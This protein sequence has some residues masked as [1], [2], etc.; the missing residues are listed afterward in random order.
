M[1]LGVSRPPA[2]LAFQ[3]RGYAS[4]A[5][6]VV[7]LQHHEM[8]HI[9]NVYDEDCAGKKHACIV[10]PSEDAQMFRSTDRH[11]IPCECI[12]ELYEL[13]WRWGHQNTNRPG[14]AQNFGFAIPDTIVVVK[15]RPYAWYFVSKKDG[16]LLRKSD[17]H[18]SFGHV[19]KA[20]CRDR[21]EGESQIC[22][23][24][25]PMASQFPEARCHSSYAEFF[26][27][28]S[29][30]NFLSGMR[31]SHSGI[32][33]AFVEPHGV[34]NFMI[35]T[36]QYREQTSLCVRTNRSVLC[37]S[38]K[39]N[40]FDRAATFEAW[41]GLSAANSRYRSHKHPQMEDMI[42]AAGEILNGRIE[43]ERV[44]QML[45]LGPT[46][47]VA[48]HFKVTR[49]HQLMFIY[50]SV[51]PEKDVILQ[52]RP[53]LLMGDPC[54]TES[55][56]GAAL[57][58]GG[59]DMKAVP[60]KPKPG[61]YDAYDQD[62]GEQQMGHPE[63]AVDQS[64]CDIDLGVDQQKQ[65]IQKNNESIGSQK[66]SYSEKKHVEEKDISQYKYMPRVGYPRP[67]VP[68]APFKIGD[69]HRRNESD[70][71]AGSTFASLK[72]PLIFPSSARE[73]LAPSSA[74][75]LASTSRSEPSTSAENFLT[76]R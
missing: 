65:N 33:Q 56:P 26:S 67:F 47:H 3:Q 45:F 54:M 28:K 43:Q 48:L 5:P 64:A 53:Q 6:N 75:L 19:E 9:R 14:F 23:A 49:D 18:L 61:S 71:S 44:R 21:L 25:Y 66:R 16:A 1:A 41:P 12:V 46:Q 36:V 37:T 57:L 70:N 27:P 29:C 50:A 34:S 15:G 42:L 11:A 55:L 39:G 72:R 8:E 74:R 7:S 17:A 60:Y 76:P 10:S 2:M 52:T 73:V 58:P 4:S 31:T 38:S 69:L 59:T 51:V 20:F 35:R 13:L 62:E 22:A 32:L 30:R 68:E 63:N 40:P 24:W